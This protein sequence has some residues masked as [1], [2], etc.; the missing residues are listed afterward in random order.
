MS[1]FDSAF[2][3]YY[4]GIITLASIAACAVLLW[5]MSKRR[6]QGGETTGHRWDEDLGEFNNPLPRWWIWLFYITIF[7]SLGYLVLYP[8]L[9]SYR[10]TLKWS[11]TGQHEA[12]VKQADETYGHIFAK[13]ASQDVKALAADPQ[14]RA[15]G[16]RL[17]LV[18]CS[19]CHGS[20]AGG[21]RGFPNLS[22]QD[23]LW[24]GDPEAIRATISG[25]RHAVMPAWG[26]VLGD[27][28]VK[29]VANYVR[30]LSGLTHDAIR[31]ARGKEKFKTTCV[32]CHGPE[33]KGNPQ[34][35]APNLTDKVWEYGASEA[36][37]IETIT[38]GRDAQMPAHG[39]TLGEARV[40]LLTAYIWGLSNKP[41]ER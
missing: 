29:D 9:G 38:F 14:A 31:A 18:Y 33:A 35:G 37:L 13:Y 15:I 27:E 21:G 19:Q 30:S 26:K 40:H 28:G 4:V 34:L 16:Q 12:E 32:A 8:G 39:D 10:G 36:T 6:L 23:W 7:F 22:D 5:A 20:D 24:G 25:G 41:A 2:W 11:S 17:F 1:D 3:E